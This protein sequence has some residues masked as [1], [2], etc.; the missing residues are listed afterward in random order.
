MGMITV[1]HV[2]GYCYA[3]YHILGLWQLNLVPS[4]AEERT[5][6]TNPGDIPYNGML[7]IPRDY[8]AAEGGERAC[9]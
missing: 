1:T 5:V 6:T 7:V 2:I 4:M 3:Y 8:R 9:K